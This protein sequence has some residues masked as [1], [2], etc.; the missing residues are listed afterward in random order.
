MNNSVTRS[1]RVRVGFN[2][3]IGCLVIALAAVVIDQW[4]R[5]EQPTSFGQVEFPITDTD[6]RRSDAALAV[7]DALDAALSDGNDP[8]S[9]AEALPED[10]ID[11]LVEQGFLDARWQETL[12]GSPLRIR[13]CEDRIGVVVESAV[14]PDPADD[15]WW[16]ANECGDDTDLVRGAFVAVSTQQADR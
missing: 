10:I 1:D 5:G 15:E 6:R 11:A 4:P 2:L 12:D 9:D 14:E 16:L 3:A 7:R 8:L 13:S